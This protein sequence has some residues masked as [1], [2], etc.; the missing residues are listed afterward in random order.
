MILSIIVLLSLSAAGVTLSERLSRNKHELQRHY[1]QS[2][3]EGGEEGERYLDELSRLSSDST[4]Q[5]AAEVI[6]A[7]TP[8]IYRLDQDQLIRISYSLHL[9]EYLLE[10]AHKSRGEQRAEAMSLLSQLPVRHITEQ[11]LS[12]FERDKDRMVRFFTLL[13]KININKGEFLRYVAS[14][15]SPLT[16]FEISGLLSLFRHSRVAVAYQP[17]L[18]TNNQ[19]LNMLGLAVVRE[20]GIESAEGALRH[21][22]EKEEIHNKV[23]H[24][25]LY[26]LATLE[27]P[28]CSASIG[29]YVRCMP[30]WERQRFLR[31]ITSMGY[32]QGVIDFFVS[33]SERQYFHSLIASYKVKIECY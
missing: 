12:S 5:V 33:H 9:A 22:V 16:P 6:A 32:S 14:Y 11:Q 8:I 13:T 10:R 17:L 18:D 19:N 15:P 3:I 25:A 28:L 29:S 27:Q 21:L 1:L 4:K 2:I 26:T 20:F 31:F 30:F 23:R 24:E 7:L